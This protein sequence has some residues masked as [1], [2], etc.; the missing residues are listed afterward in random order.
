MALCKEALPLLRTLAAP[1][2]LSAALLPKRGPLP[3]RVAVP[4]GTAQAGRGKHERDH[5]RSQNHRGDDADDD[6]RRAGHG[7]EIPALDLGN[8]RACRATAE[9]VIGFPARNPGGA[10]GIGGFEQRSRQRP[11]RRLSRTRSL[12]GT[13]STRQAAPPPT[14]QPPSR[15][16]GDCR[17]YWPHGTP[18]LASGDVSG[19]DRPLVCP[20]AKGRRPNAPQW[21]RASS[22]GS[23]RPP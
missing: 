13:R 22:P 18:S 9:T 8:H 7:S 3:T 4:E 11:E 20:G 2:R 23:A 14:R 15:C 16:P 5:D 6:E 17:N 12:A 10:C 1:R 19:G 21:S